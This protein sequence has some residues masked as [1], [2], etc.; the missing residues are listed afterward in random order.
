MSRLDSHIRQKIAQRDSIDLAARWLAGEPGVVVEF[1]L[2]TGRSYSHLT[3]RFPGR[4]VFSFD[5]RDI[6]H[7]RSRPPE[8]HLFLGEFADV[9]ADVGLHA[10]FCGRVILLHL[11]LGCG[12]P[13]DDELPEFIVGRVHG[14][15]TARALVLSDQDLTLDPA[16]GLE[17]VDTQGQVEH[18]HRYHVYRRTARY[19]P[20]TP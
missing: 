5:R 13:E 14:W 3:E 8:D 2:G 20:V 11:D 16:W 4:E 1:G 18:A 17:L 10:R 15:L 9:L 12:G 6:A 19:W 7:P